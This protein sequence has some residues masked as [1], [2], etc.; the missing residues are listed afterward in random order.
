MAKTTVVRL[1]RILILTVA[2]CTLAIPARAG[3][4][5]GYVYTTTYYGWPLV[6]GT[7]QCTAP[8]VS[9]QPPRQE[10]GGTRYSDCDGSF[11]TWGD[12]TSCTGPDN[13]VETAYRCGLICS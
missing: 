12:I 2:L 6:D 4:E 13:T 9:P 7:N 10:I 1:S 5:Y 3:C 11:T 8:I